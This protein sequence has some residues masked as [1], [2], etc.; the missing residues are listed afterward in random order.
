MFFKGHRCINELP[1]GMKRHSMQFSRL[2]YYEHLQGAHLFDTMHM[3]NNATKTL[4][5]ILDG[6]SNKYKSPKFVVKFRK[7]IM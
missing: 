4:R 7:P 1:R 6:R 2:A 3:E 5:R